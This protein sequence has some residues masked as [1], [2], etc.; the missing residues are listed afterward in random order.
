MA[1]RKPP[2]LD[3]LDALAQGDPQRVMALMLWKNRLRQP[4]M[5]VQITE[6]DIQGFDD[7]V[8][9]LKVKPVVKIERPAG[10]PAQDAIPAQGNRR[11]V[12]ARAASPAKP[13]VIV[14]LVDER[15]DA[16]RPIENNQQDYDTAAAASE[17]RKAR[18]QA[19][20]LAERL[21]AQART[22]EFSL[23]DMTD[24]ANALLILSRVA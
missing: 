13:Y 1:T 21:V 15:G 12:P 23:S 11:A 9:Y 17:V 24:A 8:A 2:K 3:P 14:T 4:D 22:G 19:A 10:L 18:D 6:H 20:A 16:I 7:C 5:Y